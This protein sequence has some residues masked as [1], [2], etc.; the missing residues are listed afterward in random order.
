MTPLTREITFALP[1][2]GKEHD[3][4][5]ITNTTHH[6]CVGVPITVHSNSPDVIPLLEFYL[7]KA[8]DFSPDLLSDGIT[9]NFYVQP[10]DS[11]VIPE[12]TIS[13]LQDDRL[14]IVMNP[15][16]GIAEGSS[17]SVTLYLSPSHLKNPLA[18]GRLSFERLV[19]YV[20]VR[21]PNLY[22]LHAAAVG[23]G[24]EMALLVGK[25]GDG[26]STLAY[27][28]VRQGMTFLSDDL[29]TRLARDNPNDIRGQGRFLYVDPNLST[30]YPELKI[31][32]AIFP[33]WRKLRVDLTRLYAS[34]L[35]QFGQ[36]AALVILERSERATPLLQTAPPEEVV[37]SLSHHATLY[38]KANESSWVEYTLNDIKR[39]CFELP[40]FKLKLS[41]DHEKNASAIRDLLGS[42]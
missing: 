7:G 26:K 19:N 3:A 10:E 18:S 31:D 38:R 40:T 11:S 23:L 39:L 37:D 34:Q 29:V 1:E 6:Y 4:I 25:R 35:R 12:K 14:V 24:D 20:L 42:A 27:S 8:L 17:R 9:I 41:P 15:S 32:Q 21:S 13:H 33:R 2:E 30:V 5:P 16:V 28:C 36:L 22:P